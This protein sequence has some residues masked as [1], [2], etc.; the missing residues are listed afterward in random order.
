[1]AVTPEEVMQARR[2]FPEIIVDC[3][4]CGQLNVLPSS[5]CVSCRRRLPLHPPVPAPVR[6]VRGA[7]ND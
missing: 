2:L 4:R 6:G 3:P 5:H 1:M 7:R